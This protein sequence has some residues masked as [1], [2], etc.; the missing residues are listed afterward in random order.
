MDRQRQSKA[1]TGDCS[2]CLGAWELG[3]SMYNAAD[4]KLFV[5]KHIQFLLPLRGVPD[6]E[7]E[8]CLSIGTDADHHITSH[9]MSQ[10][11]F[12]GSFRLMQP[13]FHLKKILFLFP[14][15]AGLWI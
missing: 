9:H 3:F 15:I 1:L 13:D 2:A 14:S 10:L 7:F 6:W 12:C 5:V 4:E 8:V 11:E